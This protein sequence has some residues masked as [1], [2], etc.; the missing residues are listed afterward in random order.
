MKYLIDEESISR[1]S[2]KNLP[3]HS[4]E[5]CEALESYCKYLLII[6]RNYN[7]SNECWI[8]L[9]SFNLN[10][11]RVIKGSESNVSLDVD[12]DYFVAINA[13]EYKN[14]FIFIHNH[15]SNNSF[16]V[17]DINSFIN[18]FGLYMIIVLQNNGV[19]N[20]LI[21]TINYEIAPVVDKSLRPNVLLDYLKNFGVIYLR[22]YSNVWFTTWIE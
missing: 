7:S 1:V 16:S 11:Y 12:L 20:I 9:D 8:L 22:R 17:K 6:S 19:S 5:S 2:I 21:K 10:K 15:P 4:I 13:D 14:K 3:Y 18:N